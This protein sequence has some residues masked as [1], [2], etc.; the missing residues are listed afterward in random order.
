MSFDN[1]YLSEISSTR[2]TSLSHGQ[3]NAGGVAT[4]K[5]LMIM[6]GKEAES[7]SLPWEIVVRDSG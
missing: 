3:Y 2:I 1:S 5:L 6:D 7:E 4:K